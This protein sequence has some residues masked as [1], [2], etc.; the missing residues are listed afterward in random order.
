MATTFCNVC[1]AQ[2]DE[3]SGFCAHCG[4]A[5]ER[6]AAPANAS[7]PYAAPAAQPA[8]PAPQ[9]A[10]VYA[11]Q[12]APQPAQAPQQFSQQINISD[13]NR[14]PDPNSPYAPVSTGGFMLTMLLLGIPVVGFIYL[15]V[16]AFGGT[17][18]INRRNF[19]RA[20][21]IWG[22]IGVVVGVL[23]FVLFFVILGA[24]QGFDLDN[25]LRSIQSLR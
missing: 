7:V 15:I 17:K 13:P 24:S 8:A 25:L 1:G 3:N 6:S 19:C 5:V 20:Y 14:A 4:A 22:L 9:P 2:L 10:P 12:P 23:L 18:K 16:C 21:L 11:A